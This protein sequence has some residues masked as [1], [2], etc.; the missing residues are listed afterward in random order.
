MRGD[1]LL[2]AILFLN[3][4]EEL[5]EAVTQGCALG[6]PEGQAGADVL[7]EGEKLHLLAELAVVTLLGLLEEGEILVEHLLLGEGDAVDAHELLALLVAAPEGSGERCDLDGLDGGGIGDVRAAA[8]VGKRAL[9]IGGDVAVLQLGDELALVFLATV[10]EELE[11]V[12]LRDVSAHDGLLLL[13]Q[14]E[15]LLLDF[16][17][18]GRGELV[19][20]R[21]DVVIETVF[22]SGTDAELHAGIQLL[23]SFGKQVGRRVPEGVLAFGV[24]PLVQTQCRVLGDGTAEVPFFVIDCGGEHVAGQL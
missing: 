24:L 18:V 10:A 6:E 5:L 12:G 2:V 19:V 8:E 22:D 14:L 1:Y 15:H 20:T 13:G 17:E 7:R 21:V 16:G 11:G 4:A 3:L 23:E 9:R